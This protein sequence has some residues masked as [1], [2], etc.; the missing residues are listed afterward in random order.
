MNS[1][2]QWHGV[3]FALLFFLCVVNL[4]E[5]QIYSHQHLWNF[6]KV[7]CM[8][9]AVPCKISLVDVSFF[10]YCMIKYLR[11]CLVCLFILQ[12]GLDLFS[13]PLSLSNKISLLVQVKHQVFQ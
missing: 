8:L 12:F 11:F 10:C 3:V 13:S 7:L 2:D 9:Q 5:L 1:K 4:Y 6:V